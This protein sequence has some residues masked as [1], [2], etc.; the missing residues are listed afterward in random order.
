MIFH[1]AYHEFADAISQTHWHIAVLFQ[2]A[3][4]VF[5]FMCRH[6]LNRSFYEMDSTVYW[7][8]SL[9][10]C[11]AQMDKRRNDAVGN[12]EKE[13]EKEKEKEEKKKTEEKKKNEAR[14]PVDKKETK[15]SVTVLGIQVGVI[16]KA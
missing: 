10:F 7:L 12:L 14:E 16:R 11:T 1:G 15:I 5:I 4:I 9:S 2:R 8:K 6:E 13:K 3:I